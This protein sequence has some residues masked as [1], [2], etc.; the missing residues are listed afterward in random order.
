MFAFR[1]IMLNWNASYLENWRNFATFYIKS[2]L[3][4][5]LGNWIRPGEAATKAPHGL[6]CNK[7]TKIPAKKRILLSIVETIT[8]YETG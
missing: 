7:N 8:L 5:Y 1:G 2:V 4:I 3:F 6:L